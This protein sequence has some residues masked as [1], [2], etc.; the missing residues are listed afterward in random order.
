MSSQCFWMPRRRAPVFVLCSN[1]FQAVAFSAFSAF[2]FQ[3]GNAKKR[4]DISKRLEELYM[5]L[6]SPS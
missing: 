2:V 6:Q 1:L 3:D 5:K 4:E